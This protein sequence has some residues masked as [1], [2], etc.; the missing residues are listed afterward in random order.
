MSTAGVL[1]AGAGGV[2][3]SHHSEKR[4]RFDVGRQSDFQDEVVQ[5]LTLWCG[6]PTSWSTK[7][8]VIETFKHSPMWTSWVKVGHNEQKLVN[9][10]NRLKI[11]HLEE[12]GGTH[13]G[14]GGPSSV[15][16]GGVAKRKKRK[17]VFTKQRKLVLK[18]PASADGGDEESGE[19]DGAEGGDDEV[20][21]VVDAEVAAPC[22]Q[23][24]GGV[25]HS[26]ESDS[27]DLEDDDDTDWAPEDSKHK[28]NACT[29]AQVKRA[30]KLQATSS[31][32]KTLD[33]EAQDGTQHPSTLSTT[34]KK[35]E[36]EHNLL[37]ARVPVDLELPSQR[38]SILGSDES[39]EYD[40]N[41]LRRS[42]LELL[43]PSQRN[44]QNML[45]LVHVSSYL[46]GINKQLL[47]GVPRNARDALALA[48][49][50]PLALKAKALG[51]PPHELNI[52]PANGG[53]IGKF[54]AVIRGAGGTGGAGGVGGAVREMAVEIKG[55]RV[56]R[57]DKTIQL[58]RL[59][60]PGTC[61]D[62]LIL[63]A[64]SENPTDWTDLLQ[65][66]DLFWLGHIP[67]ATF[68]LALR[69]RFG[70][71]VP[72]DCRCSVTIDKA[73]YKR[74]NWLGPHIRWVHFKNLTRSWWDTHVRGVL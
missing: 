9:F 70:A 53:L 29:A 24:E 64:R 19:E 8:E 73:T 45:E 27:D 48:G 55:A 33:A 12:G 50:L 31:K 63:V 72:D 3:G 67:R 2:T 37:E 61:C 69:D 1:L 39:T 58:S 23:G 28:A 49:K 60:K 22:K 30:S 42:A 35:P 57:G 34:K 21:G 10:I 44:S 52:D 18:Q 51:I 41:I 17:S 36:P 59:P 40:E 7:K 47:V 65:L 62:H 11:K 74:H 56:Y 14:G 25:S 13:A 38:N 15:L 46:T 5:K 32:R 26:A 66:D 20:D 68:D 54:D 43:L 16:A 6:E 4:A 71:S